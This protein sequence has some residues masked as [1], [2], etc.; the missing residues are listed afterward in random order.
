[1]Y[2]EAIHFDCHDTHH[3]IENRDRV[4]IL[5]WDHGGFVLYYKR[6]EKGRFQFGGLEERAVLD[7]TELTILLSG[8]DVVKVKRPA[9]WKPAIRSTG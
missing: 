1:M 7:A 6:L 4:K 9:L 2:C 3:G 5:H 8:I